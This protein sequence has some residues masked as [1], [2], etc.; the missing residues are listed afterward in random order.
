MVSTKSARPTSRDDQ[1]PFSQRHA[2]ACFPYRPREV[3]HRATVR[4]PSTPSNPKHNT[5]LTIKETRCST[6]AQSS[7]TSRPSSTPTPNPTPRPKSSS[8][9]TPPSSRPVSHDQN[10][11]QLAALPRP[12]HHH[13]TKH[14]CRFLLSTPPPQPYPS[15]QTPTGQSTP[16]A[17]T[18]PPTMA[19]P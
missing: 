2:H 12:P 10:T 13:Q 9:A 11:F 15:S 8:T 14:K 4:I 6:P 19:L 17:Q 5:T 3:F 18:S 1:Q 7:H 16:T